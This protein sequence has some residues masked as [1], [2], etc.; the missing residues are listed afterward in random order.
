MACYESSGMTAPAHRS[1]G[2][3][4]LYL[5]IAMAG[6]GSL[7]TSEPQWYL[8]YE[9]AGPAVTLD[10]EQREE[11]VPFTIRFS[12]GYDQTDLR[13]Y[14]TA[15]HEDAAEELRVSLVEPGQR[16]LATHFQEVAG[17][18]SV[19]VDAA[20]WQTTLRCGPDDG[21]VCEQ[22]L[23]AV[24]GLGGART[25]AYAIDWNLRVDMWKYGES[26]PPEDLVFEVDLPGGA[27]LREPWYY[28]A[29][30]GEPAAGE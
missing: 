14:G 10:P 18:G 29:G 25:G 26:A 23:A 21:E 1:R 3:W 9:L 28:A 24:F 12:R 19:A 17:N 6:A 2:P 7:A 30:A 16:T 27:V 4:P 13:L 22:E 5:V 15:Q 11:I 8:Q 20:A